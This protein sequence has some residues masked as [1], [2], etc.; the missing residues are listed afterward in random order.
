M[1][2]GL[3]VANWS[4]ECAKKIAS[5]PN[6]EEMHEV[7]GDDSYLLKVRVADIEKLSDM[8]KNDIGTISEVA[9]TKTVMVLKTLKKNGIPC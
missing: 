7:M 6:V 9:T 1:K 4:D 8:L 3:N 2:I 5:L